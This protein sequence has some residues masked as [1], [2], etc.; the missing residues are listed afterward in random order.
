MILRISFYH[1]LTTKYFIAPDGKKR[2]F[3]HVG[4]IQKLVELGVGGS[5]FFAE[6]PWYWRSDVAK[7]RAVF[8]P[9]FAVM[10]YNYDPAKKTWD[11]DSKAR[12]NEEFR[13]RI[14]KGGLEAKNNAFSLPKFFAVM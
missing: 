11:F 10:P 2:S 13:E 3:D 8:N 7:P 5:R 6:L 9:G 12:I 14:V 1:S 4:F